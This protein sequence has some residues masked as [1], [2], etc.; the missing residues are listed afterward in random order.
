MWLIGELALQKSPHSMAVIYRQLTTLTLEQGW[1]P[2]GYDRVR[3][4]IKHLDHALVTIAQQGAAAYREEF[5]YR[6]ESSY[7]AG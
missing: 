3:H 2:P 5:D 4:I 1:K 7:V 6:R